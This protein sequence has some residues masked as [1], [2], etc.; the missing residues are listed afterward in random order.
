MQKRKILWADD[1]PDDLML[2][3]QV[4][5]NNEDFEIV[6]V[7]NG[8]EALNYLH[9]LKPEE[10]Q[11]CL[12]IL[13]MNMPVMNG[14]ETLAIIKND[15]RYKKIP[16]VVFTTSSSELDKLFCKKY[17]AQMITKPPNYTKF[18]EVVTK[19]LS[20]CSPN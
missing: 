1:D 13:D 11:P 8:R 18:K 16:V 15:D 7:P 14:R 6:E 20:F 5:Q 19:M 17:N 12:I 9:D 2:M 3:H 4:L 10:K